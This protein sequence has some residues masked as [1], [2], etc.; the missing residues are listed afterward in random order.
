[1]RNRLVNITLGALA[2]LI[3]NLAVAACDSPSHRQFDFWLGDW[4]VRT[5]DGALAG[6]NHIAS[7]YE[8]CVLRERY[9]TPRGYRG[10]SLNTFDAGRGVWHQTWVDTDGLLLLLEGRFVAGQMRLAGETRSN[11]GTVTKH[12]ITWSSNPDG[13]VRQ[14]WESTDPSGN[15]VVAFDGRYS[16]KRE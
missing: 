11:D 9:S 6:T 12:R 16:R 14:F 15:W 2:S 10:E 7:E 3:A 1:M 4:E 8:G 5:P 13:T